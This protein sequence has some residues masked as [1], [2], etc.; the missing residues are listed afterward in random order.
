MLG[1]P[2]YQLWKWKA[3]RKRRTFVFPIICVILS[4]AW[5][6]IYYDMSAKDDGKTR[7]SVLLAG[8]PLFFICGQI[9]LVLVVLLTSWGRK[10]IH[11]SQGRRFCEW[12]SFSLL[13]CLLFIEF[14]CI[15]D[16]NGPLSDVDKISFFVV[17]PV[18]GIS[19][20][21]HVG[22]KQSRAWI[23]FFLILILWGVLNHS[24]VR[25]YRS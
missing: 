2:T 9:S 24:Q 14:L 25:L 6:A 20:F 16:D 23:F 10:A 21:H 22:L 19:L 12:S 3:L 8:I 4:I 17:L 15:I 1:S 11:E 13:V 18:V 5:V 7:S